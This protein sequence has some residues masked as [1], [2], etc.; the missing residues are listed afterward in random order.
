M[1]RIDSHQHF[2]TYDAVKHDWISDEMA[3]I[4]RDF[5][6][7]EL[8]LVLAENDIT[9]CV[10]VQADQSIAENDF[11]L[12]L[13]STHA[14]IKGVV[15][16]VDLQSSNLDQQL[17]A[18]ADL[19]IMK[20]FR[21]IL[22]GE[23]QRDL[24][25]QPA[26]LNGIGQLAA[27][28]FTYDILILPDQL[29]F[30]PQFVARFPNQRFVIDHLAKP[31]VKQQEIAAW[32]KDILQVAQYENVCCKVSGMVTEADLVSWKQEDFDPYLDVV[33]AAFGPKRLMYGS[34]WPVCLSGGSYKAVMRIVNTYF[35]QWSAHEQGLFF[36]QNAIDFY[37]LSR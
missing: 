34:D 27:Y 22:Q 35:S 9:G 33:A 29:K 12:H 28:D 24:M 10:A 21:H 37:Q 15:G 2:W 17:A 5:L 8:G 4:R 31:P 6:P 1:I 36:G 26:F 19:E 25:L 7:D 32:K 30:I 11:L 20:G 16:W 23:Q 13:A 18:Y 3:V 14:W